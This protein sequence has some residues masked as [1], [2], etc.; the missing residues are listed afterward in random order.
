MYYPNF[1]ITVGSKTF[2]PS[3]TKIF[4]I[5]V[6]CGLCP[7]VDSVEL[8]LTR[9]DET[10]KVQRGE[11]VIVKAGYEDKLQ[12][13]F[14][15]T[16]DLIEKGFRQIRFYALNRAFHLTVFRLNRVYLNQTAGN[17]VSD[18]L[19]KLNKRLV[20]EGEETIDYEKI[21]DG[22]MFPYYVIGENI[23]AYEHMARLAEKSNYICYTT[24]E[25]LLN[26]REY[27]R[28]EP[29][30]LKYGEN[31]IEISL[32]KLLNPIGCITVYG[33]SPS[34]WAGRETFH[35]LSKKDYSGT[36]G[37]GVH[38]LIL[39][40]Y[41]IKDTDT[42]STVAENIYSR[43]RRDFMTF[44]KI[45]GEP[46]IKVG[47]TIKV[48]NILGAQEPIELQVVEVEHYLSFSEGFTTLV[49][50]MEVK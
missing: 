23:C 29:Y 5:R 37:K 9:D 46:K 44:L 6:K 49:G 12:T 11:N 4:D 28:K 13:V 8:T 10:E 24:P 26:F 1:E 14:S 25:G 22:I 33:E 48:E 31:I 18:I 43:R 41:S 32:V 17:I 34:S 42:V 7:K 40:D 35:W 20:E 2:T 16:V 38:E 3:T 19:D 50:G 30:I 36:S 15:G 47:D 21:M 45:L 27:E 39:K